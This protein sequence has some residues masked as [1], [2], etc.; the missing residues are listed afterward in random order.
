MLHARIAR[1]N[2]ISTV[3]FFDFGQATKHG[4]KKSFSKIITVV[5]ISNLVMRAWSIK[6]R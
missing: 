1:F 3:V 6:C 5:I 2:V 4:L